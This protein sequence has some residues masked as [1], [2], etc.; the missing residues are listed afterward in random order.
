MFEQT[1]RITLTPYID[2]PYQWFGWLGW[3]LF[4]AVLIIGVLYYRKEPGGSPQQRGFVIV[5]LL[6]LVPICT[7]LFNY[8]ITDSQLV[9]I[10]N[11]PVE[12]IQPVIVPLFALPFVLAAG[13]L[14]PTGAAILGL[15]SG[16]ILAIFGT[17]S[18]FTPLEVAGLGLLFG[19]AVRQNYRTQFFNLLRHPLGGAVIVAI[20]YIPV[21]LYGSFFTIPGSFAERMDFALTQNWFRIVVRGIELII[22]G[23]LAEFLYLFTPKLWPRPKQFNP[24][25]AETSL[26]TRLTI[27]VVPAAV[28]LLIALVVSDWVVAGNAAH[29]MVEER[30][31]NTTKIVAE[32]IPYFLEVGQSLITDTAAT[33]L[34]NLPSEEIQNILSERIRNVPY[35]RQLYVFDPSLNLLAGYPKANLDQFRLTVEEQTGLNL[36]TEGVVVQSYTVPPNTGERSAQISFIGAITDEQ[37]VNRG[38]ILG[39]TDLESNPFT[40]PALN[41]LSAIAVDGGAG[42]I[43]DDDQNVLFQTL[44]TGTLDGNAQYFGQTRTEES[45]FEDVSSTGTRQLVYFQP[46]T[47]RPWAILASMPAQAAQ[48]IALE[49]AIPLLLILLGM[50]ILVFLL[51]RISM[52]AL[53][54]K[55]HQLSVRA[56]QIADGKL[57]FPIEVQGVDEIGVL[58]KSFEQMRVSLKTRM[59]E[60]TKLLQVSQGVASNLQI[61]DAIYPILDAALSENACSARVALIP[62]VRVDVS[63]DQLARMGAGPLAEPFS[64]LDGQIFELMRTQ[65]V[66]TISNIARIRRIINTSGKPHPLSLIAFALR[67]ENMYYGTLWIGFDQPR[68]FTN[69]EVRF[70]SMLANE[71]G[72]AAAN[73]R[74]YAAAEIGR[75]R[76]EAVLNSTPEPVLV[77]DEKD[78]LLLLN[79]AALHVPGLINTSTP[80]KAVGEVL[81]SAE[82]IKLISGPSDDRVTS[83]EIHLSNERM[84]QC[85]VAPVALQDNF[86]G[87]VCVLRD[88]T[89]YKELDTIKS[90][91]VATVSHDLR[92]PLTLMRGYTTMVNMVGDLNEQQKNYLTKM[93]SG[94]ENMTH[95]VNNLLDLGR[96]EAGIS[97][98]LKEISP[99]AIIE[100][101]LRQYY[102]QAAQKNISLGFEGL[103]DGNRINMVA[104]GDLL[105]QALINLVDNAIKYTKSNGSVKIK[106]KQQDDKIIFEVHDTGIGIAPLDMNRLFERFYRSVRREA[107][108]QRGTGLGLAIVK[109]IVDRHHGQVHIES[110]LGKGSSFIVELPIKQSQTMSSL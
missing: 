15:A 18:F 40:Q 77:F 99:D 59:D 83:Q 71:A 16:L 76:F 17:H 105:Q 49:M 4:L 11:L 47:G 107:F 57:E 43:L 75:R 30:L 27:S 52:G 65:D 86:L 109:T 2:L 64:Y 90:D 33:D 31:S 44:E 91:F 97:L 62:E 73:A 95:L 5:L 38:V 10:P 70:F 98:N 84:Y 1:T 55:L 81:S 41:A 74:L 14:G 26:Q 28:A 45:F 21:Y 42:F 89:H 108:E 23:G 3:F 50:F 67:F 24:S 82:L 22:A 104:D 60:Q 29:K 35:F 102:P 63:G 48:Q 39:R 94:V 12:S 32:S 34:V 87:K 54:G 6:V 72:L 51:I 78:R 101:V 92:T 79:P 25:P 8:R 13:F 58:G 19:V 36:A 53:T 9:P 68:G 37:G 96:I 46:V 85:G 66:L 69:D 103:P 93:V 20:G 110:N 61:N 106:L 56:R 7:L 100:K 88:I 80:G